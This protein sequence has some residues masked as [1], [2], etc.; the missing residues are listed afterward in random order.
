MIA[1]LWIAS[2]RFTWLQCFSARISSSRSFASIVWTSLFISVRNTDVFPTFSSRRV[3]IIYEIRFNLPDTAKSK[4]VNSVIDVNNQILTH[5]VVDLLSVAVHCVVI[6]HPGWFSWSLGVLD[7]QHRWFFGSLRTGSN[8][9]TMS[10][11]LLNRMITTSLTL[12]ISSCLFV[13]SA[14]LLS[15]LFISTSRACS[16]FLEASSFSCKSNASSTSC[17]IRILYLLSRSCR[18]G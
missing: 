10:N 8:V 14:S 9:S 15:S 18:S 3:F 13:V 5:Y 2:G 6:S 4:H 11:W 1:P 12:R 17:S 7:L 16:W